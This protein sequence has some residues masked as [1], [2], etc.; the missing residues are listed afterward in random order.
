MEN[1]KLVVTV[2][3]IPGWKKDTSAKIRQRK[4]KR[5]KVQHPMLLGLFSPVKK[6]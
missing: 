3:K 5:V 6:G 2:E 4:S 1:G